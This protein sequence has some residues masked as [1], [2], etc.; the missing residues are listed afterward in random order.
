MP[1]APAAQVRTAQII[2]LALLAG[3]VAL[4]A[5]AMVVGPVSPPPTA[6]AAGAPPAGPFGGIDPLLLVLGALIVGQVPALVFLG[7][8]VSRQAAQTAARLAADPESRDRALAALWFNSVIVRA[9]LAEG[10]GLFGGVVLLLK[11]DPLAL[12]GVGF[13]VAVLLA[14]V[15]TR[16]RLEHFVRR[17][18]NAAANMP[19]REPHAR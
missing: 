7:A 13:A 18:A 3:V 2:V 17:A 1:N 14:L 6:P 9:A 5:V 8:G 4:A 12:A 11:G 15:P 16:G 19:T 10:A